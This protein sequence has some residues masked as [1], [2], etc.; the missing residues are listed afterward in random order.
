MLSATGATSYTWSTTDNTTNVAVSPTVQTTYT[1][2]GTD[3][4]GCVNSTTIMQDV[5]LCT[6]IVE[7]S[8]VEAQSNSV[9]PNPNNGSFIVEL[10]NTSTISVTNYIGQLIMTGSMAAGKHNI[11]IQNQSTGIYFVK[12]IQGVKQHVIK[13]IKE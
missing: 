11:D 13:L 6:G 9:F 2:E 1:I 10:I 8:R 12:V 7:L 3:A 5:S 4:N